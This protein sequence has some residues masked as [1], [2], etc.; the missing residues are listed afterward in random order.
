MQMIEELIIL[1]RNCC[2]NFHV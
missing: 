1:L 2:A